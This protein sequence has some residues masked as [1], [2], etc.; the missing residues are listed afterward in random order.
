MAEDG[1]DQAGFLAFY[2]R[3]VLPRLAKVRAAA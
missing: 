1:P 3:E 2:A